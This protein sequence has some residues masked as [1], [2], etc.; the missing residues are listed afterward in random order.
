M[1]IQEI[2]ADKLRQM[3]GQEC[4]VIQGCGGELQEW[5][6]GINEMLTQ[7]DILKKGTRFENVYSF[8]HG[9]VTCLL[10]P[11]QED[12]Q[13]DLGKLT[14]WRLK[15]HQT[16]GSTWF[17]DYVPNELGGFLP[18]EQAQSLQKP[19]C[20]LIRLRWKYLQSHG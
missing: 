6:D 15:T 3:G 17:S 7:A 10:F 9:G 1:R 11:F 13:L 14:A 19:D 18:K 5:I 16:F 4:L 8:R 2:T 12:V 20:R